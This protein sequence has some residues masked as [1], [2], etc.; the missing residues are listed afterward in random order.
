MFSEKYSSL[1]HLAMF[2]KA[3]GLSQPDWWQPTVQTGFCFYDGQ[4][5]TGQM[6]D[7]LEEFLASG[8][9]PIVF[10]LGSAAV[11]DP[12]NFFDESAKSAKLLGR[13]A[14]LLYGNDNRPPPGLTEN[15]VGFPYAPFSQVFPKAACVVHQGGVGT[16]GQV[17]R[18][19]V[20]HLIMP[21]S[22]DQP[23]NAARCRRNGVARTIRRNRY[24]AETAA[25][26]IGE[27][28][29][30]ER[31]STRA[32]EAAAVVATEHGTVTACDAIES[33]L[34]KYP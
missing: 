24:T 25:H 15:I 6:P 22:H 30:D 1:L 33:A 19:G 31:Y 20:P 17:I 26:E 14:V 16:T 11:L 21:Y 10:T 18:A 13:R 23:D 5:D 7:G 9:R 28:L 3:L 27:L 29:N 2:S 8:E 32:R 12:G 4:Q 34:I